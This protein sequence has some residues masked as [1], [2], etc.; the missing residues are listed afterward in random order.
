MVVGSLLAGT[1]TAGASGLLTLPMISLILDPLGLP[2]ESILVVFMAIDSLIDP[3]RTLLIVYVNIATT[4]L[5]AGRENGS[6]TFKA[7][8]PTSDKPRI[9]AA[10][11][12]DKE[13]EGEKKNLTLL[14][15]DIENF[16]GISERENPDILLP[17]LKSY[18]SD[19][20]SAIKNNSGSVEKYIGSSVMAFWGEKSGMSEKN[21]ALFACRS[22]LEC[23]DICYRLSEA[24]VRN[25]SHKFRGRFA[26]HTGEAVLGK[27][28]LNDGFE[29]VVFG[30]NVN[31][32]TQLKG[33][34]KLYGTE[35]IL[36]SA[37][38]ELIK[39][40]FET[41]LLDKIRLGKKSQGFC[42]YELLC[43]KGKA[44]PKTLKLYRLY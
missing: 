26:V 19:F 9:Q 22:A 11:S 34:N 40:L 2:V 10:V 17:S 35:I 30:R 15:S 4:A 12:K 32:V 18:F 39:D 14:F 3:M 16:T 33:L 5:V 44:N 25:G 38:Q 24:R 28:A 7:A 13:A 1:A 42:I 27:M 31:L 21:Q 41:R 20:T 6:I 23:K 37:T 36:S 43:E 29:H 8:N